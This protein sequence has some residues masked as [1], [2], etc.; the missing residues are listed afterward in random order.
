MPA[1][2]VLDYGPRDGTFLTPPE[3]PSFASK[4]KRSTKLRHQPPRPWHTHN[5]WPPLSPLPPSPPS[6]SPLLPLLEP[7]PLSLSPMSSHQQQWIERSSGFAL[8][9]RPSHPANSVS[10]QPPT[11]QRN[12]RASVEGLSAAGEQPTTCSRATRP[13][14]AAC[15]RAPATGR[16]TTQPPGGRGTHVTPLACARA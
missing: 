11:R 9:T 12:Y 14:R 5:A 13:P 4:R 6:P 2:T 7:L 16:R 8:T 10:C 1:A 15:R 3:K